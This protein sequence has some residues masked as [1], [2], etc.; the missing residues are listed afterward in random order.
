M[1]SAMSSAMQLH[2]RHVERLERP[3]P[4]LRWPCPV[5]SHPNQSLPD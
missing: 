1:S 4:S 2:E 3:G 5:P